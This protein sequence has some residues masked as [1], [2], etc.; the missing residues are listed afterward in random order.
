MAET[1][2]KKTAQKLFR[3]K[4]VSWLSFN[5]RV[6]QE[7]SDPS[8]PLG[9]RIKFMGIYSANL[10]EFYR[11]RVANLKRLA[12]MESDTSLELITD[13]PDI[14]LK[15]IREIVLEQG[16]QFEQLFFDL[17]AELESYDVLFLQHDELD[18]K[19]KTFISSY[20]QRQVRPRVFPMMLNKRYKMPHL[21]DS[22]LYLAVRLHRIEKTPRYSIIE[23]PRKALPRF[24]RIPGGESRKDI[25]FID[26]I[27]R[28]GL[29]SIYRMLKYDR[30]EAYTVKI[31]RDAA[32]DL[33]DDLSLSYLTKIS[34]SL[35][36]RKAGAP[37][38][39]VHDQEM[40]ED[41]LRFFIKKLGLRD[42][43]TI[44][45]GGKYHYF[46]DFISF[47]KVLD[48]PYE[49][50]PGPVWHP[51]LAHKPRLLKVISSQDILL[52]FPFHPFNYFID[53]LREASID[54]RVESI[55][56]VLYR[57][58]RFSSVANALINAIR[59]RK[60]VSVA[61]ELQ[62]RFD[63]ESN[64]YWA[65]MLKEEGAQVIFGVQNI[66]IHAKICLISRREGKGKLQHYAAIGTGN[67]NEDTAEIYTDFM[68]LTA[69]QKI[70]GEVNNVFYFIEHSFGSSATFQHLIVSPLQSRERLLKLIKSE[71]KNARKGV[72]AYIYIK[73]NNLAD[74]EFIS[75]LYKA[76]AAGVT[77]RLVVRGMY[78]LISSSVEG[79]IK[80]IGIV[81]RYLEH[82]RVFIFCNGGEELCFISSADWMP[83]NLDR[84]IEVTCP[85]YDKELKKQIHDI[86]DVYWSDSVKARVLDENLSNQVRNTNGEGPVRA[87]D[88]I[89]DYL[90]TL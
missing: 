56:I 58:A 28:F 7:A 40:P 43:D 59:N 64:I 5:E 71:T 66:K 51:S 70:A 29:P 45:A 77:V 69:N 48:L 90:R 57:V 35:K 89:Y 78:S 75:A 73:V 19:Q 42:L 26:D 21:K 53:L 25:I 81:D 67:F 30:I 10:D 20:F 16:R 82:S 9:D 1:K 11:G 68:L 22:A 49:S 72:K 37:I 76:V 27:V 61:L 86:F 55:K 74:R 4:E 80:A 60:E 8:V 36:R 6:L 3:N 32:L 85:I 79:D 38:R 47:D 14:A 44:V 46:R 24:V 87:Q 41:M 13:D 2:Q 12:T 65:S 84:R 39:L 50:P 31:T 54:P 63:E 34:S 23:I 83:R 17:R 33:D 18:D 52:H 62:A 88:K 15:E